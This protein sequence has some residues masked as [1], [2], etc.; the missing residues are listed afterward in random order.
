MPIDAAILTISDTRT[1][2]TDRSGDIAS[3]LLGEAGH[4][5]ADRSLVIDD[6]ADIQEGVA[7]VIAIDTIQVLITIGGTG[8]GR[9]DVTIPAVMGFITQPLTGF[10]EYFRAIS[11]EQVGAM[12]MLS[13]A[14]AGIVA[15]DGGQDLL[16]AMLPGS[17][18]AVA[19]GIES[20]LL[21]V[22]SHVLDLRA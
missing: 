2:S 21:P 9:R 22:L 12:A 19:L 8:V 17:P 11:R 20:A 1:L 7:R 16:I 15:R 14:A 18:K 13:N 6:S 10:G 4:T 3:D 5:I